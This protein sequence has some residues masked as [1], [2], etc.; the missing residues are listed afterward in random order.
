MPWARVAAVAAAAAFVLWFAI[1]SGLVRPP[2]Q[3]AAFSFGLLPLALVFGAAAWVMQNGGRPE[4]A[5]LLAGLS[6]G[7]GSYAVARLL[8]PG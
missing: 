4:R 1:D 7:V 3:P 6:I 8:L 2:D 5:P